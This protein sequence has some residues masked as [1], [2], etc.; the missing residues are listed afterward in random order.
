VE[1]LN[2]PPAHLADPA[3]SN[4]RPASRGPLLVDRAREMGSG[5]HPEG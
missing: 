4:G 3:S 1:L 5:Y 2:I